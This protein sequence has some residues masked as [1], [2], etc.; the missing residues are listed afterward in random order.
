MSPRLIIAFLVACVMAGSGISAQ[1]ARDSVGIQIIENAKPV[2]PPNRMW[3]VLPQPIL[4]IGKTDSDSLYEFLLIM[5]VARLSDGRIAVGN[6][7]SGT[8]RFFNE[9]GNY[10]SAAGRVGDGPGEFRQILGLSAFRG[11]SLAV[12]DLNRVNYY[13]GLGKYSRSISAASAGRSTIYPY[14]FLSDGSYIGLAGMRS[15]RMAP[16][17][18]RWIDSVTLYHVGPAGTSI[19]SIGR[20]PIVLSSYSE[21]VRG[22]QPLVFGPRLRLTAA[23]NHVY[24]GFSDR[25]EIGVYSPAGRLISILRRFAPSRPVPKDAIAEYRQRSS[26][27][28][29]E[30]GRPPPPELRERFTRLAA[31]LDFAEKL[32]AYSELRV[33]R[34]GNLWVRQ[35]EPWED[36]PDRSGPVSIPTY[37]HP[38]SWDVFTTRGGWLGRV[39][40]PGGFAPLEIG[41]DYVAG[42]WRNVDD[43]EFVR[44]YRLVRP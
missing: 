35:Y 10:L 24:I 14:A 32:P 33:D 27:R 22:A 17:S 23:S 7:G 31:E 40:L 30:D 15:Q 8:V 18:G 13:S 29:G 44:I 5:G 19:D 12:V 6:Q 42:I 9:R 37:P 1:Q 11:D 25:F 20:F 34:T 2:L 28:P 4:E 36:A 3:R 43:I 16:R 26:T 38:S 21:T 39:E 41:F